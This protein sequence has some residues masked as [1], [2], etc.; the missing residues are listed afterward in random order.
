MQQQYQLYQQH[1]Q[2]RAMGMGMAP[3]MGVPVG[4][5]IPNNFNNAVPLQPQNAAFQN[6][7]QPPARPHRANNNN[8]GVCESAVR[9]HFVNGS[10]DK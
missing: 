3:G 8:N 1:Q 10:K 4:N 5:N 6:Q 7:M 2:N 9:V